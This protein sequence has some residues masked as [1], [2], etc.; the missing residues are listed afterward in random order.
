MLRYLKPGAER[1]NSVFDGMHWGCLAALIFFIAASA[2]ATAQTAAVNRDAQRTHLNDGALLLVAGHPELTLMKV[3]EDLAIALSDD[4]DD[5]R[6]V[7]V[8]GDG[9]EGNVR[10]VLLL[11]HIDAGI[12]DLTALEKLR[13]SKDL[14]QSLA[15]ELAHV[16]TLFPDKIQILARKNIKSIEDLKGKRVSVGLAHGSAEMHS[17]AIFDAFGVKV[18][19]VNLAAPDS[20]EALIKGDIDAFACFCLTTPSVYQRVMFDVDVHLL[21]IPFA[22][23]LQRDYLPA[24]LVHDDFPSFIAEGESIE[25]VAVTLAIFTYNWQKTNPRYAKVAKFVDRFFNNIS[26]LQQPPRHPEW[27]SVQISASVDNWPR[28]AAAEEWQN[29]Q[30][31]EAL[32]DMRVAFNEF[33]NQ[34]TSDSASVKQTEQI[35]LFEEFLEWRQTSR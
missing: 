9:A 16:V 8:V 33:L 11:R 6:V 27:R 14:S 13:K 10:D 34:W 35:K 15:T 30:R 1:N 32:Q 23:K 25:T 12:T 28:F 18:E 2:T 20:A 19:P 7:P 4:K 3:A 24:T 31:A 17:Q 29:S 26:K 22:A 21:P 5:F